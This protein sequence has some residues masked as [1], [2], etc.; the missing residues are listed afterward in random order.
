MQQSQSWFSDYLPVNQIWLLLLQH[1][2]CQYK[3]VSFQQAF[4]NRSNDPCLGAP[5]HSRPNLEPW[6]LKLSKLNL[7]NPFPTIR[8]PCRDICFHKDPS[9]CKHLTITLT[10][11][12]SSQCCLVCENFGLRIPWMSRKSAL[13]LLFHAKPSA[14]TVIFHVSSRFV[15]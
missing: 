2:K 4:R 10:I 6:S 9:Q 13:R 5:K 15:A 1:P 12:N 3:L 8:R 11:P 7:L 14:W